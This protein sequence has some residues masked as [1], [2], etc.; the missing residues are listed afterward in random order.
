MAP[1]AVADWAFLFKKSL[2]RIFVFSEKVIKYNKNNED[3]LNF[4][5]WEN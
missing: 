5:L 1:S 2:T 4:R 3:N